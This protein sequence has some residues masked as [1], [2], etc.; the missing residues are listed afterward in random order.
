M[1]EHGACCPVSDVCGFFHPPVVPV[2]RHGGHLRTELW[3]RAPLTWRHSLLH[4]CVCLLSAGIHAKNQETGSLDCFLI[5]VRG[6][7]LRALA[8]VAIVRGAGLA[9]LSSFQ[10]RCEPCPGV[11]GGCFGKN[12]LTRL[13]AVRKERLD[14]WKSDSYI[15]TEL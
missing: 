4:C 3:R 13:P 14:T 12:C 9:Q 11:A 7:L 8:N 6:D 1:C 15:N 10:Y 5:A 2:Y